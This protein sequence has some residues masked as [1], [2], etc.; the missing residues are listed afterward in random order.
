MLQIA[1]MNIELFSIYFLLSA[2]IYTYIRTQ[3]II[4]L[5]VGYENEF[6]IMVDDILPTP[7][8]LLHTFYHENT[9]TDDI[10]NEAFR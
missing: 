3:T 5:A 1:A 10:F 6:F 4:I 2:Y 9:H 7:L 8:L